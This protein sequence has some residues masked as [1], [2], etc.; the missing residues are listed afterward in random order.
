MESEECP[1]TVLLIDR[2]ENTRSI[3]S[4]C[5]TQRHPDVH[6]QATDTCEAGIDLCK[7]GRIDLVVLDVQSCS[8]SH[9]SEIVATIR[10]VNKHT[11]FVIVTSTSN[12]Q[13][14]SDTVKALDV[15]LVLKPVGF[16]ALLAATEASI[17]KVKRKPGR[18]A[19]A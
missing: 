5:V 13:E 9:C 17:V 7:L 11:E 12:A 2:D 14:L 16:D 15:S 6:L 4:R 1:V 10:E 8:D 19:P 18:C 3:M